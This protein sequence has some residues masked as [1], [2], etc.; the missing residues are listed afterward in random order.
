MVPSP[1]LDWSG[2]VPLSVC[3]TTRSTVLMKQLLPEPAGPNTPILSWVTSSISSPRKLSSL[4]LSPNWYICN[5]YRSRQSSAS[6]SR[7]FR[8]SSF[9]LFSSSSLSFCRCRLSF[10]LCLSSSCCFSFS[11]RS[12]SSF[13]RC[14]RSFSSRLASLS[15]ALCLSSSV[16][17]L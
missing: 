3:L 14:F 13:S 1:P 16:S 8:S 5:W 2:R 9:L 15:S 10:S 12:P 11:I 17:S 6:K 4:I 7:L